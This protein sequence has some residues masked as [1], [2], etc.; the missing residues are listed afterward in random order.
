MQPSISQIHTD[1]T[2]VDSKRR[3]VV[4]GTVATHLSKP[5]LDAAVSQCSICRGLQY[6]SETAIQPDQIY[7]ESYFNGAE[8][9]NYNDYIQSHRLNFRRKINLITKANSLPEQLRVLEIGAAT[10][11]FY[12]ALAEHQGIKLESYL[13]IEVSDYA[14]GI[15]AKNGIQIISPFD[16]SA[17]SAI[18]L[19]R[20]NLIVAWDLWEHLEDPVATF[21]SYLKVADR[22]VTV[23]LST[24]DYGALVPK[25]RGKH[26][27]QYHP[28]THL[29]YPTRES[30]RR[31][32][33]DRGFRIAR[34]ST[35]GSYRPLSEYLSTIGISLKGTFLEGI[36]SIPFHL[37][38][39][40]D[41]LVIAK[42][43]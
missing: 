33:A 13:G 30:F 11:Q 10:G 6:K 9:V 37:N 5:E 4:C 27:R 14:R 18:T 34:H 24:V 22:S 41:Q 35:F 32:F 38:T 16:S 8:Y 21:D 25:I 12:Q 1:T 3:C 2:P 40:D 15:A 28:P 43:D 23:A 19:I 42:R 29:S 7:D 26:W 17:E 20:P 36:E 31:Y 39:F